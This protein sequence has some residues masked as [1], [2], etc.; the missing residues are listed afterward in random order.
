MIDSLYYKI[1][2]LINIVKICNKLKIKPNHIT[3]LNAILGI[4]MILKLNKTLLLIIFEICVFLDYL[5]GFLAR[6]TNNVS[7]IGFKLDVLADFVTHACLFYHILKNS[8]NTKFL[9]F[10]IIFS[11]YGG[12]CEHDFL[13]NNFFIFKPTKLIRL[14][15]ISDFLVIPLYILFSKRKIL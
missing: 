15:A 6:E 3:I 10:V 13:Q 9:L 1:F 14:S 8:N 12:L 5:D 4:L 11:V 2:N 7:K